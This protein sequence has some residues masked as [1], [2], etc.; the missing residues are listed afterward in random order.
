MS[1]AVI[2]TAIFTCPRPGRFL[3]LIHYLGLFRW[4]H[5]LS[6]VR[7]LWLASTRVWR[8]AL[9]MLT[10]ARRPFAVRKSYFE[11]WHA[12]FGVV[13]CQCRWLRYLAGECSISTRY[14]PALC[15]IADLLLPAFCLPFYWFCLRQ[16][17]R[18]GTLKISRCNI[19]SR[20]S[21]PVRD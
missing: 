12:Y 16:M 1:T 5:F 2:S 3:G 4:W 13:L 14:K 7:G 10:P 9:A 11:T 18:P 20:P 6:Y 19:R 17:P 8:R 15:D 21:V